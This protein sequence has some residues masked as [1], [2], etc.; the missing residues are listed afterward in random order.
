MEL[1]PIAACEFDSIYDAMT[2]AFPYEERRDRA[3]AR[4]LLAEPRYRIFHTVEEGVRVGF[5][6]LWELDGLTFVEHFVTYPPYRNQGCGAA[7]IRL[8]QARYQ[9]LVLEVEHPDTP[10]AARRQAFYRRCGFACNAYPYV[11]P[12]YH[13]GRAGVPLVLMSY[14]A[15]LEDPAS[16]KERLYREVY[17]VPSV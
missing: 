12:S 4:A 14:P 8:L 13:G 7:V 1:L 17:R 15:A 5:V 9:G 16:V 2:E 10:L 6:T 3:V 11:Q